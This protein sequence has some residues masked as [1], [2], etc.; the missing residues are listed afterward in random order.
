MDLDH[1]VEEVEDLGKAEL[2]AIES[3]IRQVLVHLIKAASDPESQ[4]FN[5]WR[6]E[7]IAINADMSGRY[8]PS[9]RQLIDMQA[10][11]QLALKVADGALRAHGAAVDPG[12]P[13]E[14]PFT[15]AEL[16]PEKFDVDQALLRV[17]GS[18]PN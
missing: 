9:M 15:I 5:H 6:A 16:L 1:L 2:H 11:W 10:Q 4:A 14:C 7:A 3:R 12:L 13:T 18:R 8:T 17:Q